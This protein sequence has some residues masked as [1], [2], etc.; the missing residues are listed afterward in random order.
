MA[1]TRS[2]ILTPGGK[3]PCWSGQSKQGFPLFSELRIGCGGGGASF[4]IEK[5]RA[6]DV[7]H[8]ATD[9][10]ADTIDVLLAVECPDDA[11]EVFGFWVTSD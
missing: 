5:N 10:G 8:I 1:A 7:L 4:V 6:K 3:R 9:A 11:M 2:Q